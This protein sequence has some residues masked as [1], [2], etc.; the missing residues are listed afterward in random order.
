MSIQL[1][2]EYVKLLGMTVVFLAGQLIG[3]SIVIPVWGVYNE[4]TKEKTNE[5]N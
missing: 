2:K 4:I 5:E 3:F 1:I